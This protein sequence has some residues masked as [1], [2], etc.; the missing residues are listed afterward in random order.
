[1]MEVSALKDISPVQ[2]IMEFFQ[3]DWF[4]EFFLLIIFN[5][6]C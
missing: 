1:M 2:K 4:V 6:I 3:G 5:F